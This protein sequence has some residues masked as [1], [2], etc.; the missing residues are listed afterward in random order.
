MYVSRESRSWGEVLF[1]GLFSRALV[2]ILQGLLMHNRP[3]SLISTA[4]VPGTLAGFFG[5]VNDLA[6]FHHVFWSVS[7]ARLE[8]AAFGSGGRRSIKLSY[9]T[10]FQPPIC[11]RRQ[12]FSLFIMDSAGYGRPL[13]NLGK[14]GNVNP[15]R[16]STN[17]WIILPLADTDAN[18]AVPALRLALSSPG[19]RPKQVHDGGG[20]A[21]RAMERW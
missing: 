3:C 21:H 14:R 2:F 19:Q 13:A 9:G 7:P 1:L 4:A 15:W 18:R 5:D 11:N 20:T 12:E 10:C 6:L 17:T 16:F 8:L